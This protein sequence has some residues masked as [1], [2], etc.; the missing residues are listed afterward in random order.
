MHPAALI[1]R[2]LHRLTK[3]SPN[4][5]LANTCNAFRQNLMNANDLGVK[6][7]ELLLADGFYEEEIL[8]CIDALCLPRDPSPELMHKL[9]QTYEQRASI[10]NPRTLRLEG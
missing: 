8:T 10:R 1:I 4:S 6:L 9:Q 5:N 3:E 7:S 2:R